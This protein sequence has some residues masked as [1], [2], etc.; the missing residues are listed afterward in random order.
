MGN[1]VAGAIEQ[2]L[3]N[4]GKRYTK[5]LGLS[6]FAL[7]CLIDVAI[8]IFLREAPAL[9][10]DNGNE[11]ES[12]AWWVE[13]DEEYYSVGWS[14]H[15]FVHGLGDFKHDCADVILLTLVRIVTLGALLLLGVHLGTPRLE[16][17]V[18]AGSTVSPLVINGGDDQ[19]HELASEAKA[20]H[21]ESFDRQK[22][23][24]V[25]KNVVIAL[26]F[27]LSSGCQIFLGVKVISFIGH[28]EDGGH[29]AVHIR[30]VQAVLFFS[31]VIAINAEAFIAN[32][33]V[34]TLTVEDGFYVPEF[35]QHRCVT[36][37]H[38]S[39]W[40]P[41]FAAPARLS[42]TRH[43]EMTHTCSADACMSPI[44]GMHCMRG[45][46]SQHPCPHTQSLL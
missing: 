21:L 39:T 2:W 12:E 14:W 30:T 25:R 35:H 43:R 40:P 33:L 27:I 29:A 20:S 22:S 4:K 37:C 1:N 26:M 7:C 5:A 24:D 38:S 34:N 32:R 44:E 28:W 10:A 8:S 19:L 23:A 16:K 18:D 6:L 9:L 45:E 15:D 31:I 36:W 41:S 3:K 13:H 46:Q 42:A 11:S 17:I